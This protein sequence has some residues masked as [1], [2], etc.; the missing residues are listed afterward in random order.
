MQFILSE[1]DSPNRIDLD[2]SFCD[3]KHFTAAARFRLNVKL[4]NQFDGTCTLHYFL[5]FPNWNSDVKF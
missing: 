5:Q 1:H 4:K 3:D 2:S